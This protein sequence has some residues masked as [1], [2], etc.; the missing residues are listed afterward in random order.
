V[1]ELVRTK[2]KNTPW[3]GA[4]TPAVRLS[5]EISK[6]EKEETQ[7]DSTRRGEKGRPTRKKGRSRGAATTCRKKEVARGF[8]PAHVEKGAK[9]MEE[10]A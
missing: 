9:V 8:E 5:R 1:L 7:E 2:E 6:K 3:T 4:S 10:K